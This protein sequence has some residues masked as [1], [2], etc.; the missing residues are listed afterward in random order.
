MLEPYIK[1]KEHLGQNKTLSTWWSYCPTPVPVGER[2]SR[3]Y[4]A[5]S[6]A[7]RDGFVAWCQG[8]SLNN[9]PEPLVSGKSLSLIT[10]TKNVLFVSKVRISVTKC[11]EHKKKK[12]SWINK[13][14]GLERSRIHKLYTC[15]YF[16]RQIYAVV[17]YCRKFHFYVHIYIYCK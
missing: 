13:K 15:L 10:Y 14:Y 6:A 5:P 8:A 11:G 3:M 17:L 4:S 9:S 2:H 16:W 7:P 1:A 12:K